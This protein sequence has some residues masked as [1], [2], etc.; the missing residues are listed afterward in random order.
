MEVLLAPLRGSSKFQAQVAIEP[1]GVEASV[2]MA[3]LPR[4][5]FSTEKEATGDGL[6]VTVF[7]PFGILST[8]PFAFV[9]INLTVK[10]PL[11]LKEWVGFGRVEVLF[12]PV[13]GSPKVQLQP[14]IAD[15]PLTCDK[16]VN[17]SG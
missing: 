12:T 3:G 2:N 9:T 11:A 1:V 8:H 13:E 14:V 17:C 6:T 4:H 7:T 5:M 10:V 16:S 15:P